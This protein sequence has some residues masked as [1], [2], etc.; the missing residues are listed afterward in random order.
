MGNTITSTSLLIWNSYGNPLCSYLVILSSS[1]CS[2]T[3]GLASWVSTKTQLSTVFT[4]LTPWY[5]FSGD[6]LNVR[7][8]LRLLESMGDIEECSDF[9]NSE[10]KTVG[11]HWLPRHRHHLHLLS[12]RLPFHRRY[13]LRWAYRRGGW[14]YVLEHA[15]LLLHNIEFCKLS[16]IEI[17]S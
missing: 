8:C 2:F 12:I 3:L 6:L 11:S 17:P 1:T 4:S 13:V 15:S 9:C 16:I 5:E 14:T 7:V 10:C